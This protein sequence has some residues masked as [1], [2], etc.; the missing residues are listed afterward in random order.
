MGET[1]YF[2]G[3]QVQQD[4]DQ[5]TIQLTQRPYW[6]HVLSHFNL[7][8]IQLRNVPLPPGTSLNNNMPPKTKS[9]IKAMSDKPYQSILGSVIWG[10]LATCPDLSFSVSLL[11]WFQANPGIEHWSALLQV[12]GYIKNTLDYSLTYLCN[13]DLTP[14][15]FVNTD[16]GG[17]KDT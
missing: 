10:Q 2:L 12:I 4:L 7:E 17:C 9:E 15:A 13:D 14:S 11:A 6:E 1:E 8:N 16:Y 5:G 3:M